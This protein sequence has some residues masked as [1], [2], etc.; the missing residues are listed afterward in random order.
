MRRGAVREEKKRAA[1]VKEG[2]ETGEGDCI[3]RQAEEGSGNKRN[4]QVSSTIETRAEPLLFD[5]CSETQGPADDSDATRLIDLSEGAARVDVVFVA[6]GRSTMD[7][8]EQNREG[9]SWKSRNRAS[10]TRA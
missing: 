9:R 5:H 2:G 4:T 6:K 3:W 8:A 7:R 1:R 10:R